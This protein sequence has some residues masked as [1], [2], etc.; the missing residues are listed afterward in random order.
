MHDR[1]A[2]EDPKRFGR[3]HAAFGN[4]TGSAEEPSS[5][6][7][8]KGPDCRKRSGRTLVTFG[9]SVGFT[10]MMLKRA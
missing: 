4:P 10:V 3:T 8:V 6:G 2:R 5:K 9:D 7:I 1:D